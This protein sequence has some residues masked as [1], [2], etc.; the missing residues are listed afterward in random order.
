MKKILQ[1]SVKVITLVISIYLISGCYS[2]SPVAEREQY[3][4]PEWVPVYE[5]GI[6]YYY[7]PDI[8]TYYDVTGRNFIYLNNGAWIYSNE[9]PPMYRSYDLY[10]GY[11]VVLNRNVYQ[12]WRYHQNYTSSYPKYYYRE[13][14]SNNQNYS[15]IRGYNENAR[16]PVYSNAPTS[17]G[18]RNSSAT[19]PGPAINNRSSTPQTQPSSSS[20]P[21]QPSQ[22]S[23][24]NNRR[25][26]QPVKVKPDMREPRQTQSQP[27]D[28]RRGGRPAATG[29]NESQAE[30]KKTDPT[31]TTQERGNSDRRQTGDDKQEIKDQKDKRD[32][33]SGR[34]R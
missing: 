16:K 5:T 27:T 24:V 11:V 19:Q 1:C 2:T 26:G 18:R 9:L 12:P 22:S 7:M 30:Q 3:G 15:N 4:A 14:Y 17:S 28:S 31:P 23:S 10:N 8:E 13:R 32:Q 33:S 25:V 34:R 21:R 6:R 29:K 20:Q